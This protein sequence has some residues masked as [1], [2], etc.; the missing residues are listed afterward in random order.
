MPFAGEPW[1]RCRYRTVISSGDC[2]SCVTATSS[3]APAC[4]AGW[5]CVGSRSRISRRV[6]D[7]DEGRG[8]CALRQNRVAQEASEPQLTVLQRDTVAGMAIH[9]YR[10]GTLANAIFDLIA[11]HIFLAVVH[12][13]AALFGGGVGV[14]L[15][16]ALLGLVA[17]ITACCSTCDRGDLLAGATANLVT[18][19]TTDH[20]TG[21]TAE[22]LVLVLHRALPGNGDILT[23]LAGNALILRELDHV[24]HFGVGG[25]SVRQRVV[26][27]DGAA[28]GGH[29]R[30]NDYA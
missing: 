12:G 13:F 27:G 19:H 20:G 22:H 23:D 11:D 17:R 26:S 24:E 30:A 18:Q 7:R 4:V 3:S 1:C 16:H 8:G 14:V 29:D 25:G 28:C 15:L 21:D 10:A 9:A 6:S 2:T 5:N